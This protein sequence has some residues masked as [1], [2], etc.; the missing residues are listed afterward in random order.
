MDIPDNRLLRRRRA[1]SRPTTTSPDAPIVAEYPGIPDS[2]IPWRPQYRSQGSVPRVAICINSRGHGREATIYSTSC[3]RPASRQLHY[4][5][6]VIQAPSPRPVVNMEIR[7]R[8]LGDS[9]AFLGGVSKRRSDR[10]SALRTSV[11]ECGA[12]TPKSRPKRQPVPSS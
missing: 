2:P 10:V 5:G 8:A 9:G 1:L 7:A 3:G 11:R 4:T 12:P 6:R